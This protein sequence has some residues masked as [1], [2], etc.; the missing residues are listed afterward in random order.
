M[1][2]Y[3]PTGNPQTLSL[4]IAR[5]MRQEFGL[6]ANAIASK[7]D[8]DG[9]ATFSAP[10]TFLDTVDFTNEIP[11]VNT[12]AGGDSSRNVANTAFVAAGLAG[13][14]DKAGDSYT[15]T[16]NATGAIFR[17]ATRSDK[18]NS[19]NAASTAYV[20]T[21]VANERSSINN[22]LATKV[23]KTGDTYTGTHNATGAVFQVATQPAGDNS[24]N[25]ASTAYVDQTAFSSVLPDQAGNAGKFL[26]T[27]GENASWQDQQ[28]VAGVPVGT[29][30]AV[31]AGAPPDGYL[32]LNGQTISRS[33]YAALF[34]VAGA[35]C[36]PG[37][38]STTFQLP[39][40][41]TMFLRCTF[42][43]GRVIGSTQSHAFA[44]HSHGGN[45]TTA[46]VPHTHTNSVTN[47]GS[48]SH[49]VTISGGGH[50][51]DG[52]TNSQGSHTH[53]FS[54]YP[55]A[56]GGAIGGG[57]FM[58]GTAYS[59]NTTS[60][61]GHSHDVHVT[62]AGSNHS[63]TSS[64]TSN[65]SHNHTVT[66]NEATTATAH[67]HRIPSQGSTETRPVNLALRFCIKY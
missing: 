65:G 58:S 25:A 55:A 15:G 14:V 67:Y 36:G 37:D 49:T 47:N 30:I 61:G 59:S 39:A 31:L 40:A 64:V 9:E 45:T 43:S 53:Q 3:T 48:H 13:K 17:V 35:Y 6:I 16:H 21:R 18:D 10:V 11:T 42:G 54:T 34:A 63:H 46:E 27:D 8:K 19:N 12:A 62:A 29:V 32:D 20:D 1:S 50:S 22:A 52:T 4:A 57:R 2:D 24:N 66:I 60:A 41:N 38:G 7:I 5:L 28:S 33:T 56:A 51:H 44:S 23:T 26:S